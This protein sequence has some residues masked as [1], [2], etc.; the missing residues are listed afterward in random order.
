MV[1][2]MDSPEPCALSAAAEHAVEGVNMRW[3]SAGGDAAA[4]VFYDDG[5]AALLALGG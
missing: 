3:R 4:V 2:A 1:W 5:G